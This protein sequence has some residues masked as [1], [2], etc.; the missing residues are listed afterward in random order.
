M[1]LLDSPPLLTTQK[2]IFKK[3]ELEGKSDLFE[4]WPLENREPITLNALSE[5]TWGFYRV[6]RKDTGQWSGR[7]CAEYGLCHLPWVLP[8]SLFRIFRS[9]SMRTPGMELLP[10]HPQHHP[11]STQHLQRCSFFPIKTSSS[12]IRSHS[13]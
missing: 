2:S 7:L 5:G 6:G 8:V 1:L 9:F 12:G 3:C 4:V 10:L 13:L 11:N